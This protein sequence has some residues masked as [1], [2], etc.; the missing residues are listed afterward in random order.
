MTKQYDINLNTLLYHYPELSPNSIKIAWSNA[1]LGI[2]Y[3][4]GWKLCSDCGYMIHFDEVHICR[5][6]KRTMR[7][8][9]VKKSKF[10][11][12]KYA[13]PIEEPQTIRLR[14]FRE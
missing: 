5:I 11:I 9:T 7:T 13:E 3:S 14:L 12:L 10:R 8:Q 4:S 2:L 1:Q 6:C